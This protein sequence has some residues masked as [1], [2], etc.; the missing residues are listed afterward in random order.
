MVV[1]LHSTFAILPPGNGIVVEFP[2]NNTPP[3]DIGAL[4]SFEFGARPELAN[5]FWRAV[6]QHSG[7][8]LRRRASC[9]WRLT[10]ADSFLWLSLRH[11]FSAE[12]LLAKASPLKGVSWRE[13]NSDKRHRIAAIF[14]PTSISIWY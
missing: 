14:E 6:A 7:A 8:F 1:H 4:L 2:V 13:T 11:I 5:V 12:F 9:H 10:A 3:P